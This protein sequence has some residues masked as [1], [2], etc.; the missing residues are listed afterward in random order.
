MSNFITILLYLFI[1]TQSHKTPLQSS[2]LPTPS[3]CFNNS[4]N[5]YSCCT[6]GL[7]GCN[8]TS[9]WTANR[10]EP[11]CCLSAGNSVEWEYCMDSPLYTLETI[12]ID[13]APIVIGQN[14][15]IRTELYYNESSTTTTTGGNLLLTIYAPDL[16]DCTMNAIGNVLYNLCDVVASQC[17]IVPGTNFTSLFIVPDTS[18]PT[19]TS[20]GIYMINGEFKDQNGTALGCISTLVQFSTTSRDYKH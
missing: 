17:P 2:L 14:S 5:F 10:T 3:T 18:I 4:Y 11:M 13:P 8:I 1:N 12:S 19:N 20:A 6:Q 15:T 7:P 9:C 16:D